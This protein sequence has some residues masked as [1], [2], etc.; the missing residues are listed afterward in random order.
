MSP[1]RS[2]CLRRVKAGRLRQIKAIWNR[3]HELILGEVDAQRRHLSSETSSP[4]RSF[5]LLRCA[6]AS[7]RSAGATS[8]RS[9]NETPQQQR[10]RCRVERCRL[11]RFAMIAGASMAD[12]PAVFMTVETHPAGRTSRSFLFR[13]ATPDTRYDGCKQ[14][15]GKVAVLQPRQAPSCRARHPTSGG[16]LLQYPAVRC[17]APRNV[18]TF[19]VVSR[20]ARVG[21]LG[22][23]PR[24]PRA[25]ARRRT[26]RR[27]GRTLRAAPAPRLGH[28]ADFAVN[29]LVAL[30]ER[31]VSR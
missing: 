13:Q 2:S 21:S 30:Q 6:I 1:V 26:R 19:F 9:R 31:W 27:P 25:V 20:E 28:R 7:W 29:V 5:S 11:D 3:R 16:F 17:G 10:R 15:A 14:C 22:T 24:A 18:G 23:T 4:A 12:G 8:P